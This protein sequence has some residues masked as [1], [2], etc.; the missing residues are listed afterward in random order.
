MSTQVI[1]GPYET[2][3]ERYADGIDLAELLKWLWPLYWD[4]YTWT[5]YYSYEVCRYPPS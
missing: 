1:P 4:G 5:Q 2:I 3:I